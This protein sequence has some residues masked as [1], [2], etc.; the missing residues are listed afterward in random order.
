MI[1]A[2]DVGVKTL[3]V[4][5][6]HRGSDNSK[7]NIVFWDVI[8]MLEDSLPATCK[9]VTKK[10]TECG[11]KCSYNFTATDGETCAACKT[12]VPKG[13]AAVLIKT[14]KI[15]EYT[16]VSIARAVNTAM[17]KLYNE[18]VATFLQLQKIVIELQPRCNNKMKMVSHIIFGKLVDLLPETP[19]NFVRASQKLKAYTGPALTCELK[20][21]YAKRKWLS[22]Q[23]TQWFL[24]DKCAPA[25]ADVWRPRFMAHSKKDDMADALCMCMVE[26][27]TKAPPRGAKKNIVATS[28][29][30][31][32]A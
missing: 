18:N 19:I 28:F 15:K 26:L 6:V 32:A 4:C 14:K 24:T 25:V 9:G 31:V 22:V 30:F 29:G 16:L 17:N 27:Y 21:E 23:Y 2:I 7:F 1:L 20:G 3:G 12:H 8:N 11:K 5:C 13:V 10:G